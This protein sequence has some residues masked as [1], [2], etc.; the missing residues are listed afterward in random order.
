MNIFIFYIMYLYFSYMGYACSGLFTLVVWEFFFNL[1]CKFFCFLAF[2]FFFFIIFFGGEWRFFLRRIFLF[3]FFGFIYWIFLTINSI[4]NFFAEKLIKYAFI[5]IIINYLISILFKK[6]NMWHFWLFP[7]HIKILGQS[8]TFEQRDTI[9]PFIIFEIRILSIKH[10]Q[11]RRLC[12]V[13]K[14]ISEIRK[15][16]IIVALTLKIIHHSK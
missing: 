13:S 10:G 6:C 2:R 5:K 12:K 9:I 7:F 11:V 16:L 3:I 14:L 1:L 8:N 4:V 15:L